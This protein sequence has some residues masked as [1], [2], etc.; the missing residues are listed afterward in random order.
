[1]SKDALHVLWKVKNWGTVFARGHFRYH[2][3]DEDKT[4]AEIKDRIKEVYG[5]DIY[6]LVCVGEARL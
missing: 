3:K 1:M 6:N 5:I 4:A 2:P